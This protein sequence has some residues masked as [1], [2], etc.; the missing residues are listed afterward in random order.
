[1]FKSKTKTGSQKTK[2]KTVSVKIKT[3]TGRFGLE[4][5]TMVSRTTTLAI[6]N[7]FW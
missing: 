6:W 5:K 4:T 1:M 2:T 7:Y 3:K